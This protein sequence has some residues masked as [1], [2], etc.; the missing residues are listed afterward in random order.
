MNCIDI[1]LVPKLQSDLLIPSSCGQYNSLVIL[2]LVNVISFAVVMFCTIC[3]IMS[4][5]ISFYVKLFHCIM[6]LT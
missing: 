3:I 4:F 6:V 5:C 1:Q 2:T